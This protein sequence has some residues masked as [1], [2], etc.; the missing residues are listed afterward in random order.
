[1][2][3]LRVV[4]CLHLRTL[5]NLGLFSVCLVYIPLNFATKFPDSDFGELKLR[6][7]KG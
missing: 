4:I 3:R 6:P 1:M 2:S 5:L 7:R